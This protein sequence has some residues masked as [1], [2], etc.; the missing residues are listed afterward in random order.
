[1]KES[2]VK[3]RLSIHW[4]SVDREIICCTRLFSMVGVRSF[5]FSPTQDYASMG[6]S[7][8]PV[9]VYLLHTYCIKM[10]AQIELVFWH[11]GFPWLNP[12]LCF[13]EIRLSAEI[14]VLSWGRLCSHRFLTWTH[15]KTWNTFF[16]G[17]PIWNT[18]QL[19]MEFPMSRS[20]G[21]LAGDCRELQTD[22]WL[23]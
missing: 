4:A 18:A 22:R 2:H 3:S 12:S 14:T 5:E 9:S 8:E 19:N 7:Y 20:L 21:L 16:S 15:R 1:V 6:I 11:T 23:T 13:K 17:S 10:S